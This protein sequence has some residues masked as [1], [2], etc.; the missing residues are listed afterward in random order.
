MLDFGCTLDNMAWCRRHT[1]VVNRDDKEGLHLFVCAFDCRVRLECFIIWVREPL[2]SI[3]MIRPFL[4]VLKKLSLTTKHLASEFQ[5]DCWS[6]GFQSL[7]ITNLVVDHRGS[8][9]FSFC[10]S[11]QWVHISSAM[12]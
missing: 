2:S 11:P 10:P 5:K 8:F 12:S 1:F 4:S 7:D 6:C 3:H 9:L